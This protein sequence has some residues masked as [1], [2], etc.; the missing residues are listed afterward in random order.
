MARQ[1]PV[2]AK[3]R[4]RAKRLAKARALA[5][6]ALQARQSLWGSGRSDQLDTTMSKPNRRRQA[7]ISRTFVNRLAIT[8]RRSGLATAVVYGLSLSVRFTSAAGEEVEIPPPSV[9][10]TK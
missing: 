8:P 2:L 4:F 7:M 10:S 9:H 6:I 5:A 3:I 1:A